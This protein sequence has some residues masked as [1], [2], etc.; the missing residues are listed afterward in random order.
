MTFVVGTIRFIIALGTL[1]LSGVA[2]LALLGFA[3][4]EFDLFNH[5]QFLIFGIERFKFKVEDALRVG[6]DEI[7]GLSTGPVTGLG[8]SPIAG[9]LAD[10]AARFTAQRSQPGTRSRTCPLAQRAPGLPAILSGQLR[11]GLLAEID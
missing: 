4:P 2:V 6:C 8:A 5:F 11:Q 3:V 10:P 9:F 1:V 7:P